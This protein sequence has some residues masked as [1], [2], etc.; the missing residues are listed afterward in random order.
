MMEASARINEL[1]FISSLFLTQESCKASASWKGFISLVEG[2][3]TSLGSDLPPN[4]SQVM[5]L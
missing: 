3:E 2:T 1:N 4:K 5:E